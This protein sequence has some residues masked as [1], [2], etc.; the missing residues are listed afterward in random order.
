MTNYIRPEIAAGEMLEKQCMSLEPN[1]IN[2]KPMW[3]VL[4]FIFALF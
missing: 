2:M 1:R 4:G 3:L